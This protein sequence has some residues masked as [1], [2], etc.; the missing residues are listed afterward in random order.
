MGETKPEIGLFGVKGFGIYEYIVQ[1]VEGTNITQEVDDTDGYCTNPSPDCTRL[2]Q[3]KRRALVIGSATASIGAVT[4]GTGSAA[5]GAIVGGIAGGALGLIPAIFTFG[6]SIP[7]GATVGAAVG[8][9]TGAVGGGTTVF[10]GGGALGY[11]AYLRRG[12]K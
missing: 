6:L 11:F 3:S 2:D 12:R 9:T 1:T 4:V 8:G 10:V 7:I 5:G